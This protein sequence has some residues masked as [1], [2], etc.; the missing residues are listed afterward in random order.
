M[1]HITVVLNLFETFTSSIR[2]ASSQPHASDLVRRGLAQKLISSLNS[3]IPELDNLPLVEWVGLAPLRSHVGPHPF[4]AT[5]NISEELRLLKNSFDRALA[6]LAQEAS[7]KSSASPPSKPATPSKAPLPTS[8]PAKL[9]PPT[10]P[11]FAS[12][13]RSPAR[14]SLVVSLAPPADDKLQNDTQVVK[15]TPLEITEFLN[16]VLHGSTHQVTL[17]AARWTAKNNLV[18][19]AGP[20]TTAHHLNMASHFISA[21]L[22]PFL[23][24]SPTP[25]PISSRE[26]VRWSRILINSIPTGASHTRTP[27]SPSECNDAL[28]VDNPTYRSL[29]LT[30]LPS[31]VRPPANYKPNSSSSLVLAF[32]D[33]DG[34]MLRRLLAQRTLYAFGSV[35]ELKRWK[36]K[37]RGTTNT[38]GAS[39]V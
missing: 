9:A 24:P 31:W 30:Q 22:G 12:A 6:T 39:P 36:Q 15:R 16:A 34:K 18:L 11:S 19:T 21:S 17:S 29:R 28:M 20:D 8:Q 10:I 5:P 7:A 3:P 27:Y 33:P 25:I 4:T 35:G 13:T 23:S 14:P 37:P 26:N 1:L 38:Q 2:Q 32:E